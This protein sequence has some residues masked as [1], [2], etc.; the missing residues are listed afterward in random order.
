MIVVTQNIYSHMKMS[1]VAAIKNLA[2]ILNNSKVTQIY[3]Y[4]LVDLC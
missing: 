3:P 4:N 1:N 2:V